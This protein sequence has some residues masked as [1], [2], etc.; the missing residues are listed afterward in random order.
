[1]QP[2]FEPATWEQAKG[3]FGTRGTPGARIGTTWDT[4]EI[5]LRRTFTLEPGD[6]DADH[7]GDLVLR[8]HHDEDATVYLNGQEVARLSG[9]ATDYLFVPLDDEART[10]L[11][12][13]ENVLAIHVRQ[14]IGGQYIDAGLG[15]MVWRNNPNPR[16]DAAAE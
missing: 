10:T 15:R 13:G 3:G 2:Q 1:M 8:I 12:A 5:W 7:E 4:D 16:E 9:F 14:T 6:L 11:R